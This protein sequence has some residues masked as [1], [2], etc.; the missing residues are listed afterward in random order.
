MLPF[1]PSPLIRPS[2]KRQSA[3]ECSIDGG[4]LHFGVI[5]HNATSGQLTERLTA[6]KA[7]CTVLHLPLILLILQ[8]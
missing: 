4:N 1:V 5:S 2:R 3:L 7:A 8:I 6:A